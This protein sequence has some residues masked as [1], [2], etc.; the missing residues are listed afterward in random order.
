MLFMVSRPRKCFSFIASPNQTLTYSL[1]A[2]DGC[3]DPD[4]ANFNVFVKPSPT[5]SLTSSDSACL[6]E[7]GFSHVDVEPPANYLYSWDN[8]PY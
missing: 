7:A 1:I 3:S 2:S 4:T 8:G 6:G 5:I